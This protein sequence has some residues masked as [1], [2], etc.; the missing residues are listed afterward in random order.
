[1]SSVVSSSSSSTPPVEPIVNSIWAQK[2]IRCDPRLVTSFDGYHVSVRNCIGKT[3][4]FT[5][6]DFTKNFQF[7]VDLSLSPLPKLSPYQ[8]RMWML[9]LRDGD[10]VDYNGWMPPVEDVQDSSNLDETGQEV[11]QEMWSREVIGNRSNGMYQIKGKSSEHIVNYN[12]DRV[13]RFLAPLGTYTSPSV[14]SLKRNYPSP[15]TFKRSVKTTI[16]IHKRELNAKASTLAG[17]Y[18]VT[19]FMLNWFVPMYKA[20][21]LDVVDFEQIYLNLQENKRSWDDDDDD[22]DDDDESETPSGGIALGT[23]DVNQHEESCYYCYD[24]LAVAFRR[25]MKTKVRVDWDDCHEF[26]LIMIQDTR[27]F[28]QLSGNWT[29]SEMHH[30]LALWEEHAIPCRSEAELKEHNEC[31]RHAYHFKD[32]MNE[33]VQNELKWY[34]SNRAYVQSDIEEASGMH[35]DLSN[36]VGDYLYL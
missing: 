25:L 22:D 24:A 33:L 8:T 20:M 21:G 7:V 23:V 2:A 19:H 32:K 29:Q 10:K 26:D 13:N 28:N 9:L 3:S 4:D 1:M 17:F 31:P 11:I 14:A 18:E 15:G 5:H 16:K 36:I 35:P 27:Y 6:S 12:G 30:L 34:K